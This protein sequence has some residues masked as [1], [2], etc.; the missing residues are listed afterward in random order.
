MI[1]FFGHFERVR[2]FQAANNDNYQN[3]SL[4][5]RQCSAYEILRKNLLETCLGISYNLHLMM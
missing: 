1:A 4:G 3:N 2:Y 5:S